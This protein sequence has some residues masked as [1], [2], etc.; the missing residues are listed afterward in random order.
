MDEKLLN[1]VIERLADYGY[2]DI[3]EAD[4]KTLKHIYEHLECDV[5][6][7]CNINS[8][9]E[10]ITFIRPDIIDGICYEF[11]YSKYMLNQLPAASVEQI[12]KSIKEGDVTITF[13]D[14][15]STDAKFKSAVDTLKLNN[16]NLIRFRRLVW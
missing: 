1:D 9:D 6:N 13:T 15:M 11:L 2:T 4:K 14:S 5:I 7:F 16:N 10:I 8:L 12:A 3:T